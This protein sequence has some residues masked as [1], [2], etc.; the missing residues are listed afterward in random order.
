[1]SEKSSEKSE[2]S[3]VEFVQDALRNHVAPPGSGVNVGD[4]IRHAARRL[5]WGHSR[6]KDAW[7]AAP[8][9]SISGDELRKIEE[10]TGLR[11]GRQELKELDELIGRADA[12][13]EGEN[14]DLYRP[15]V[16]AFRALAR[17]LDRAGA[18]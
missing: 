10:L 14:A 8:R 17:A 4:R 3:C 2:M 16:D 11:Y 15:I 12:L 5:G 1:M 7:Y 6:T 9:I 13:L 18:P